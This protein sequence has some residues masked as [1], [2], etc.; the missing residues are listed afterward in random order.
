MTATVLLPAGLVALV[1]EGLLLAEADGAEAIGRNAQRNEI[2]LHGGGAAIA[3]GQVVFRG[4]TL[5]A[6][7][8]DGR[9][10]GRVPLQEV[11][12]LRKGSASVGTNVGFVVVEIGIAHFSQ[13]EF[14]VRGPLW[15]RRRRWRIHRDGCGGTGG[16]ARTGGGNRVSRGVGWGNLSGSLS[17]HGADLGRDGKLRSIGGIPAQGR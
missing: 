14:V 12:G 13:K 11:R 7:A 10:D 8:F 3:Q 17:S 9:L 4:A 6:V 1:A 16:A 5:V 15:R 2:L